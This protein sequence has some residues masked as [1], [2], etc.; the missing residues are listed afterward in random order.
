MKLARFISLLST[1]LLLALT[2]HADGFDPNA[3][4]NVNA[5]LVQPDGRVLIG[6]TFTTVHPG[7]RGAPT[8]RHRL[9]R[10]NA[11]GSLDTDF[12]P[13]LD[14]EVTTLALQSDGKILVGGKFTA[15]QPHNLGPTYNRT[16]LLRLNA[17]GS[18]DPAFD[19]RPDGASSVLAQLYAIA[20]QSD[21]KIL[22]GGAFTSLQPG[23]TGGAVTRSRL[24][25]LNSDGS[26][27]NSFATAANNVV[28][29]L[30]V[31][32]DG[33]ILVG[34]GFTTLQ[35][36]GAAT[37]STAT[38]FA[39]LNADGSIDTDFAVSADN[40]VLTFAFEAD[41]GILVGGD[42]IN[43]RGI[44]D[45]E[46]NARSFLARFTN[47]G[48]LD[49]NFNP[50]ASAAVRTLAVQRDGMV[51]AGGSFTSF[52]SAATGAT[53]SVNYLARLTREGAV[54]TSFPPS[55]NAP[56]N[57]LA[58]QSDGRILL[59]GYFTR[60]RPT[61]STSGIL[62][63]RIARVF[64]DGALDGGLASGDDGSIYTAAQESSGSVIVGGSFASLAG[65]TRY[66]LA[67]IGSDGAID[68]TFRPEIDGPVYAAVVQTDGKIVIGGQFTS[69]AGT[70]RRNLAR[71]NADGS[72]D[73]NYNP[74][75][76]AAVLALLL[77][78]DGHLLVGGAFLTFDLN[79]G[80]NDDDD[81]DGT[82]TDD[83]GRAYLARL[84]ADGT[85]VNF[86]LTPNA[87]ISL[88]ARQSDGKL[89]IGGNFTSIAGA[90]RQYFARINSDNTA[91]TS[92][93]PSP[94]STVQAVAVQTDGKIVIGGWFTTLQLD[95]GEADD[96]DGDELTN[97]DADRNR[98]AR[99]N[100]DGSLD[101]S[102]NPNVNGVVST[103]VALDN[104]R[105]LIGGE[106][107]TLRGGLTLRDRLAVLNPDGT[108]D[109]SF[110]VQA[111]DSVNRLLTLADGRILI[112]GRF[113][114]VY[115]NAGDSVATNSHVSRLSTSLALETSWLPQVS[116]NSGHEIAALALQADGRLLAG[117]LFDQ[118]A[119]RL[120]TNLVRLYSTGSPDPSFAT[121]TDGRV[122][123]LL[124]QAR[125]ASSLARGNTL[126]WLQNSG[127][128]SDAFSLTAAA[129]LS[130]RV[131]ALAVTSN[132]SL[133]V[134]GSFANLAGT[135][136]RN[137]ARFLSN[138]TLD[139]AFNP[140]PSADVYAIALQSDGKILL[141]GAFTAIGDTSRSYLA[142][143]NADGSLDTTFAPP[144]LNGNVAALVI[145]SDGKIVVGG[146]FTAVEVND[147]ENDDDD[148]DGTT[149]DDTGRYYLARFNADG[150]LD[151]SY[152]PNIGGTVSALHLE[153]DGRLL[154]GGSFTTVGGT[155]RY[156]LARLSAAGALDTAFD[157]SPNSAV[158][159]IARTA[160]GKLLLAG[161]FT[162]LQLSDGENDDDDGDGTTTEDADRLYLARLN[163][164]DTLDLSFKVR[165]NSTVNALLPRADGR[166]I[167]SGSF[168]AFDPNA[169][170]DNDS[171][172]RYYFARLNSDGTLDTSFNL[173]ANAPAYAL[174]AA[175]NDT[176]VAGG[177][178][179]SLQPE[180]PI[181]VGGEFS[182]IGGLSLPRLAR[183]NLDGNVDSSFAP[184]PNDTV[185][186]LANDPDGRVLVAGA[187]T[188]IAGASRTR[189]ARLANDGS[190]DTGFAPSLNGTVR[191]LAVQTEGLILVGGDFTEASGVSRPRLARYQ[192]SGALDSTFNPSADGTVWAIVPLPSGKILVAG[193][194]SQINSTSRAYLARL[195][196]D[197]SLDTAFNASAN[198][199][200]H[201]VSVQS[202]GTLLVGGDFTSI[203]GQSINRIARLTANGTA[204]VS[205]TSSADATV[206]AIAVG[207]DGRAF[208]GGAFTNLGGAATY[209]LGQ[210]SASSS[211]NASF[212][213]GSN[214]RSV[215][216]TLTGT[217]PL[218]SSVSLAYSVN[219]NSW[220]ELGR[221]AIG[222][223]GGQWSWSGSTSLPSGANYY[224][225]ARAV[226]GTTQG[227]SSSV[228]ETTWQF[229]NT[230]ASGAVTLS[231]STPDSSTPTTGTSSGS[232]SSSSGSSS[233]TS[234]T[235]S[236]NGNS[237]GQFKS[238]T[239][240]SATGYVS[241]FTTLATLTKDETFVVNFVVTGTATRRVLLQAIGPGL[242]AAGTTDY[243]AI[244][245]LQLFDANST[246]LTEKIGPTVDTTVSSIAPKVGATT[247][248]S[249]SADAAF[250]AILSPG[251][252]L[253]RVSDTTQQGGTVLIEIFEGDSSSPPRLSAFS[254]RGSSA[255]G[256]G[257][258]ATDFTITGTANQQVLIRA[259]G[260]GLTTQG[261]ANGLADPAL[262]VQNATTNAVIAQ[263]DNWET[264]FT[265]TSGTTPATSTQLASAASTVGATALNSGSRDAA[266][267]LT[268]SP[269]SYVA[270]VTD[271]DGSVGVSKLEIFEIPPAS[272]ATTTTTSST[273][274]ASSSS[275]G[276]GGAPSPVFLS[277]LGILF[278]LRVLGR[279]AA[280]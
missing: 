135:T 269:G 199:A 253:T 132:G 265:V 277:I 220:T 39:R 111:N 237:S 186:A 276:G 155:S 244:P 149:T 23:G 126:A 228:V 73:F 200:V 195:N 187:F 45:S 141:G 264:A 20:V 148:S 170:V 79:D 123:A 178:F 85:L 62:R 7:G 167:V 69:V 261:L 36:A 60:L 26:I 66:N 179:T 209:L 191:A 48:T 236:D 92:F 163:T 196:S 58:V 121:S 78:S 189:L 54:D 24:A 233:S 248:A 35:P 34:G 84:N 273:S 166:L 171:I 210:L 154:L 168:T 95:D 275:G 202:D 227:A 82:T 215:T 117:G 234:T 157:P 242:A 50:R 169:D 274:T 114:S 101:K 197:G 255:Q 204:N 27:D 44:T 156:Y 97:D 107:T 131:N 134:G 140:A 90:S 225:R 205:F 192:S 64:S 19:P 56:V 40:R 55:V 37:A 25:R 257:T 188:Q 142:R 8:P 125:T 18:V 116:T 91:D 52:H 180:S 256:T 108:A 29:A 96:D 246:L 87:Q 249:T 254:A 5:V 222:S 86:T 14:G 260:P 173:N 30:A 184:Q 112:A 212:T 33:K 63:N 223:D 1:A 230:T 106:F 280:G 259:I 99:L 15:A 278:L 147:G 213:V 6:G 115:N 118:V 177:A 4:G 133:L 235:N 232:G 88:L 238:T 174:L 262:I 172:T 267:L 11:D 80:E 224:L 203:G 65:V 151:T 211:T 208:L 68:G 240:G 13:S 53:V 136:S 162:T 38:R 152:N 139:T 127:A 271:P 146:S 89:L 9:A 161:A 72:I 46:N 110:T 231:A 102:Y 57:T 31:Q 41:G 75:P 124:V 159:A 28:Y 207:L 71:L 251:A 137:L 105:L 2:A 61:G 67:R 3:N 193:Q 119:G 109:A 250:V 252:Y 70:D 176:F 150:T 206:R 272:N 113:T 129:N 164:D 190:I 104:N 81:S 263:N 59:G 218:L 98:L 153:S 128:Y 183:L 32:T 214:L 130:G 226:A 216:L 103:L 122:H 100:T 241:Q 144:A 158:Y 182:T 175:S 47:N 198:G 201:S 245:R 12:N 279:R 221:A 16:G 239:N 270:S 247:I 21:G 43:V 83:T 49:T 74:S 42:F 138:G 194:F 165:P 143:L 51:L 229:Y 10:L 160:D 268:L 145:Q 93:R 120:N 258:F 77:E 243:A 17:D 185:H 219:G 266:V 94:N 22:I 76:D 181:Y 217:G